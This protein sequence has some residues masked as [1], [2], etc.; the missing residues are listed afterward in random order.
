MDPL[1]N[2]VFNIMQVSVGQIHYDDI[3]LI[4]AESDISRKTKTKIIKMR[5][6]RTP[7]IGKYKKRD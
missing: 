7:R 1:W 5:I 2:D 4:K 6:R 3:D